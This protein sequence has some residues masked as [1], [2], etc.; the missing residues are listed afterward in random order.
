MLAVSRLAVLCMCSCGW[1][2]DIASET[3]LGVFGMFPINYMDKMRL[4]HKGS[5]KI[6]KIP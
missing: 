1:K 2:E 5:H 4:N 3:L 6:P